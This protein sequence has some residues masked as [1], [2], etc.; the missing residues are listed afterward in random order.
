MKTMNIITNDISKTGIKEPCVWYQLN[1]FHLTRNY[2]VDIMHDLFEGVCNYSLTSLLH[3]LIFDLKLFSLGTLNE[4]VKCL[5]YN[6]TEISDKP[7]PITSDNL[8]ERIQISASKMLCFSRYLGIMIGDLVP[9][10]LPIWQVWCTLREII[11]IVT[12]PNIHFSEHIRLKVAIEEHND[13]YVQFFGRL[14][15]KHHHLLHYHT[16]LQIS[17]P[18]VHLWSMRSEQK[19]RESK[20]TSNVLCNFK[21]I[22]YTSSKS[23]TKIMLPIIV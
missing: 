12:A 2:C 20:M 16:I 19:H 13:L 22:A 6:D 9:V 4:R 7:P 1:N 10:N 8:K 11:D 14:K 5:G 18:L 21:N 23:T 3:N 17:G 15:S